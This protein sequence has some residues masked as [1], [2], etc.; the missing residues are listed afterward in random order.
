MLRPLRLRNL[1][2]GQI[3][4][5]A[6]RRSSVSGFAETTSIRIRFFVTFAD[7]VREAGSCFCL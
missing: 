5:Q 3:F 7:D 1:K 6:F 4:T 2:S